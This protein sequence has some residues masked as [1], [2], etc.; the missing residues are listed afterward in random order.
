MIFNITDSVYFKEPIV[1]DTGGSGTVGGGFTPQQN[2]KFEKHER[3]RRKWMKL[4]LIFL[5]MG[6]LLQGVGIWIL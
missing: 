6:F 4:G 5:V 2:P 3:K 1:I